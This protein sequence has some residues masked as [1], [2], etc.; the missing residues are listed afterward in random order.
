MIISTERWSL[1]MLHGCVNLF[2]TGHEENNTL[3]T[4]SRTQ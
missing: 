4:I 3:Y 2:T 1:Y